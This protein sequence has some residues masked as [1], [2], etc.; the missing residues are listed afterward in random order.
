MEQSAGWQP[1]PAVINAALWG[2]TPG[3]RV[4]L[5]LLARAGGVGL[6]QGAPVSRQILDALL[7]RGLAKR[8]PGPADHPGEWRY[9]ATEDGGRLAHVALRWARDGRETPRAIERLRAAG[10]LPAVGT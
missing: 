6:G 1:S 5:V 9:T 10:V 3:I 8:T 2:M 4:G 7:V